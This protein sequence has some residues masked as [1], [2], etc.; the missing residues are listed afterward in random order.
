DILDTAARMVPELRARGCDLVIALA[1]TGLRA[2]PARP[3]ME[4][5]AV[6]LAEQAGIDAIVAGH[7]HQLFPEAALA[8]LPGTDADTGHVH[9]VPCVQPGAAGSHLGVIDLDLSADGRGGWTVAESRA[10]LLSIDP[11][12]PEDPEITR[13]AAPLHA[14]T[15]ARMDEAVGHS[16][17]ALHSYFSFLAPDRHL[18]LVAR[19]QAEALSRLLAGRPEAGLPLLSAVAPCKF[20]GR[21]GPRYFTDV[22]PGPLSRRHIADLHVFPNDLCGVVVT[23][24]EL[25]DWLEMSASLFNVIVPGH[26]GQILVDAEFAGHNFDVIHGVSY[27]IDLAATPRFSAEGEV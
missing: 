21:S 15:R 24:S 6:P 9:G 23:G 13:L 7:T 25:R 11:V 18:S 12:T 17:C 3:G 4:N 20:G 26:D 19:A 5:A 1:H 2:G 8:A 22:P 14:R 10:R 16:A 27:A